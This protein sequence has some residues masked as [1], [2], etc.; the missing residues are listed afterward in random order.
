[1]ITVYKEVG[2]LIIWNKE[3]WW[4]KKANLDRLSTFLASLPNLQLVCLKLLSGSEKFLTFFKSLLHCVSWFH[5]KHTNYNQIS[6]WNTLFLVVVEIKL[7]CS[8]ENNS[9]VEN[10]YVFLEAN[11]MAQQVKALTL[12]PDD[13]R[14]VLETKRWMERTNSCKLSW[15]LHP[16]HCGTYIH[17]LLNKN[18]KLNIFP[19]VLET[20]P[21]ALLMATNSLALSYIPRPMK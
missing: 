11:E 16:I 18:K 20:E 3:L 17:K 5:L 12:R 9:V 13:L 6:V 4:E 14:S 15:D 2:W 21:R 19:S 10:D 1:M 8:P 7:P